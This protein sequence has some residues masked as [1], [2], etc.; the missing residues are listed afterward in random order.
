[1]SCEKPALN[2]R[3]V[4][5]LGGGGDDELRA[6]AAQCADC[7]AELSAMRESFAALGADV[8]APPSRWV[9][10]R[11]RA[12]ARPVAWLSTLGGLALA[13]VLALYLGIQPNIFDQ[14]WGL[15]SV[16]LLGFGFAFGVRAAQLGRAF[17]LRFWLPAGLGLG[18]AMTSQPNDGPSGFVCLPMSFAVAAAPFALAWVGA[19]STASGGPMAGAIVG[20]GAALTGVAVLRLHCPGGGLTH[21][22][23]HHL[24]VVVALTLAGAAT[25][26]PRRWTASSS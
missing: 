2:E 14:P 17:N 1:M 7:A 15:L 6:H 3:L 5:L 25:L 4:E 8:V 18:L 9:L 21:A 24:P 26:R 16:V 11:A 10:Q 13:A 23:E 20:G 19:R 12:A 22:L